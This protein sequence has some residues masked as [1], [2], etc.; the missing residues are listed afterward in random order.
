MRLILPALLLL[1]APA[2]AETQTYDSTGAYETEAEKTTD[3]ADTQEDADTG[4]I[5]PREVFVSI[6][7]HGNS[8]ETAGLRLAV[9]DVVSGCWDVSPLTVES[10]PQEPYYFDIRV[11]DYT[12]KEGKCDAK[13]RRAAAIVPIKKKLLEDGKIKI[14]RLTIGT[15]TDRYNVTY[16]DGVM[17]ILPSSQVK[18]KADRELV[19]NFARSGKKT[20]A[21]VALIVPTAPEGSD[22]T[23]AIAD[24]AATSGLTPAPE[25]AT[26]S[27]PQ[28]NGGTDI[29]YYY[30]SHHVLASRIGAEF[31]PVGGTTIPVTYDL[32]DGRGQES[33]PA[34]VYAKK[35]D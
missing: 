23:Q 9:P 32:R 17:R 1:A 28:E 3:E 24:F 30:D 27:L 12:Q 33:V 31:S 7:P 4:R 21:L 26:S 14:L 22:T 18:F 19:H 2:F 25:R 11:K 5:T 29:H 13:N 15:T 16:E 10:G 35:I 8:Y 20:G 34:P 6:T